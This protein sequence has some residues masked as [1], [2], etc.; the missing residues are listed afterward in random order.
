MITSCTGQPNSNDLYRNIQDGEIT[1]HIKNQFGENIYSMLEDSRGDLWFGTELGVAKYDGKKL[2]YLTVEDGLCGK[3]VA[4][5]SE[6]QTGNIWFGTHSNMCIYDPTDSK[7][8][9]FPMT[10]DVPTLGYGWKRVNTFSD[11][12]LWVSTH[13]GTYKYDSTINEKS[14]NSFKELMTPI[15]DKSESGFCNTPGTISMDLIDSKGH[16]WF[17]TDGHGVFKYDGSEYIQ[18]TKEDGLPSNNVTSIIEDDEGHMWFACIKSMNTD[19]QDGGLCRYNPL[20]GVFTSFKN[21]E[22]LHSN[23]IFTAYKHKLGAIWIGAIGVGIYKFNPS[24]RQGTEYE[25]QLY[26]EPKG[27]NLEATFHINGLMSMLEDKN[28]RHWFG[29]SGGLYY[30]EG[31]KIVSIASDSTW[32]Y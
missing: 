21:L 12:N 27:V 30:L 14:E 10:G 5:I 8:T 4:N 31:D 25:F 20:D 2:I 19:I 28:G 15:I 18:L 3:T 17:G 26:N 9:S 11:G 6:D 24:I 7:F 1:D 23:N 29:Y 16:K 32:K 13:R 22:G